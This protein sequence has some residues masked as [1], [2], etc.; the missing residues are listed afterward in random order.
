[1]KIIYWSIGYF[2][3]YADQLNY[4]SYTTEIDLSS[5]PSGLYILQ[6]SGK[7]F[8]ENHKVIKK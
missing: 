7:D 8:I 2:Y 3:H 5:L 1:M 4:K 6:I